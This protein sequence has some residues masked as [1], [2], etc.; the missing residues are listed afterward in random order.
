MVM[1]MMILTC[2]P[3]VAWD[4]AFPV[5]TCML[6]RGASYINVIVTGGGFGWS[7]P[8]GLGVWAIL[9]SMKALIR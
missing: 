6:Q 2:Y 9:W 5:Y 8:L 3:A 7:D 1:M 4:R